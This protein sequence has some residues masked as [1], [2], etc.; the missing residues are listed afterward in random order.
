MKM[1]SLGNLQNWQVI[2]LLEILEVSGGNYWRISGII[3]QLI[4]KLE[5][6]EHYGGQLKDD[7]LKALGDSVADVAD[8]ADRMG[9]RSTRQQAQRI[10]QYVCNDKWQKTTGVLQSELRRLLGELHQRMADE[11]ADRQFLCLPPENIHLYKQSSP[12]FGQAV[13]DAFPLCA[14]DISE[15]SKCLALGRSTATVFHLMR[16][17]EGAVAALSTKLNIPNPDREWGKLLS[18]ITAKIEAMPKGALRDLWSE[19]R[20]HLY[21]VKQ[22]WRNNTMHPK[23]TYTPA[24][25]KGIYEAVKVFMN[26]LT[27]LI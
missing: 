10:M 17:M 18:D 15:A 12:P 23:Q 8:E 25:A 6:A 13:D 3:G 26:H 24:E 4:I 27:R 14:E 19:S 22:A 7:A 1:E 21:H 5:M 11:L 16:A 2:S 20:T 9:L